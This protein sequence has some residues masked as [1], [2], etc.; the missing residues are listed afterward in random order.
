[1]EPYQCH[2]IRMKF[3]DN[4]PHNIFKDFS[5]HDICNFKI[6]YFPDS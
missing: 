5:I 4:L 2:V 3:Y 1:M 6:K